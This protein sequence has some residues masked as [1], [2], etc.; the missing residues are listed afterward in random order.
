MGIDVEEGQYGDYVKDED[1]ELADDFLNSSQP[2]ESSQDFPVSSNGEQDQD[3]QSPAILMG[4]PEA[5]VLRLRVLALV[6]PPPSSL[7]W[8][9]D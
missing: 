4:G 3:T 8:V 1:D 2:P 9:H 5:V 7:T 6:C